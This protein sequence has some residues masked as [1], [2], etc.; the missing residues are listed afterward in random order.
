MQT[1]EAADL[2]TVTPDAFIAGRFN[3]LGFGSTNCRMAL[4]L[5]RLRKAR[6]QSAQSQA[7]ATYALEQV[8]SASLL[9][10]QIQALTGHS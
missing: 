2:N 3:F 1:A 10:I 9:R 4:A 7:F 5:A 6:G 8:G